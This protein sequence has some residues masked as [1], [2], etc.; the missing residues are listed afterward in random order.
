MKYLVDTNVLLRSTQPEDALYS[1]A[2]NVVEKLLNDGHTLYITPQNVAE[3]WNSATRPKVNNGL[4]MTPQQ[5]EDEIRRLETILL[6]A[7]DDPAIYLEWRRIVLDKNVTG[8][9]VHDARLAAA[10]KVYN[11]THVLTF[12][13]RDFMRFDGIV[14]VEPS[15]IQ[16]S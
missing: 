7:P 8:V 2:T 3:F 6:L 1:V 13:A 15:G 14:V 12:N 9:L 16:L 4:G 5:A 11:I 10:M